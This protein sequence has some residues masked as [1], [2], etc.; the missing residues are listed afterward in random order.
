MNTGAINSTTV[1]W[2]AWLRLSTEQQ[3]ALWR[4]YR[5]IIKAETDRAEQTGYAALKAAPAGRSNG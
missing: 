3:D 4:R 2:S 5:Q 1:D